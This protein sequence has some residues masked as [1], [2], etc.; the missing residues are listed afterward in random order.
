M[1]KKEVKIKEPKSE[2]SKKAELRYEREARELEKRVASSRRALFKSIDEMALATRKFEERRK[3]Y[4]S[5]FLEL[6]KL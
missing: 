4:L 1:K 3:E 2:I 5:Y 6:T